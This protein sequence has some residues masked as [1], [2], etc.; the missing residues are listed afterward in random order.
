MCQIEWCPNTFENRI[1]GIFSILQMLKS[2]YHNQ[3]MWFRKESMWI[4]KQFHPTFLFIHF[5]TYRTA[6]FLQ[7]F[8]SAKYPCRRRTNRITTNQMWTEFDRDS[9]T[10]RSKEIRINKTKQRKMRNLRRPN[11]LMKWHSMIFPT[12][13]SLPLNRR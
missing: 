2:I 5:N 3:L 7:T 9:N 1:H 13:T 11:W 4:E 6:H 10:L 12:N 8:F